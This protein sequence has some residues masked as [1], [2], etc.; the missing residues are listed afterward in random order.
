MRFVVCEGMTPF[1]WSIHRE[2]CRHAKQRLPEPPH[3]TVDKA[4]ASLL[5]PAVQ[6]DGWSRQDIIVFPCCHT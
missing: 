3:D 5:T 1:R 4:V 6:S 2:G